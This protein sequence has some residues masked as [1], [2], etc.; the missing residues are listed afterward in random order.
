MN[1]LPSAALH[2]S[3]AP[4]PQLASFGFFVLSADAWKLNFSDFVVYLTASQGKTGVRWGDGVLQK[5][6]NDSGNTF[7][8][9]TKNWL[10]HTT[11]Y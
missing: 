9:G 1:M 3:L 4:A 8:S 10:N 11:F 2:L 5:E 6:H 7:V